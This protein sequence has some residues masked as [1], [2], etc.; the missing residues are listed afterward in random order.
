LAFAWFCPWQQPLWYL[1]APICFRGPA[2][3]HQFHN[4]CGL[5]SGECKQAK[6]P[7]P[8]DDKDDDN[9]DAN[10]VCVQVFFKMACSSCNGR[11]TLCGL[12]L[13]SNMPFGFSLSLRAQAEDKEAEK[14]KQLAEAWIRNDKAS[15]LKKLLGV[16]KW[17]HVHTH[18]T[19]T[20][21]WC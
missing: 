16:S 12:V 21:A 8:V 20:Q 17:L 5:G 1:S 7:I 18:D 14:S 11:E 3:Y 10:V 19:V 15:E 4:L 9:H 6:W 2:P 13:F